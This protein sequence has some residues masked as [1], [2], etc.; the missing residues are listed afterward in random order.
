MIA[1][2]E[3]LFFDCHGTYEYTPAKENP[4]YHKKP[5]DSTQQIMIDPEWLKRLAAGRTN[6]VRGNRI[7]CLFLPQMLRARS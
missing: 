4:E 7:G 1:Y 6:I 3:S 2:A 5:V